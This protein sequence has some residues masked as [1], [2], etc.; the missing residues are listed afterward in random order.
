MADQLG[1]GLHEA[2]G[3]S[4]LLPVAVGQGSA[5][6]VDALVGDVEVLP[7]DAP[8]ALRH[9]LPRLGRP[10]LLDQVLAVQAV[11]RLGQALALPVPLPVLLCLLQPLQSTLML[12]SPVCLHAYAGTHTHERPATVVFLS[13]NRQHI[14]Q[15][16]S[17]R[18]ASAGP[19][20]QMLVHHCI[21]GY[22]D[23]NGKMPR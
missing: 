20:C 6:D 18:S 7:E 14:A 2:G 13:L 11:V 21:A 9:V 15:L 3:Q 8:V 5:G 4:S 23:S 22:I 16:L 10:V 17:C 1:D 19:I 12:R